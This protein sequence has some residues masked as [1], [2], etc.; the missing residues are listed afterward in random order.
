MRGE[1]EG[2][3][4]KGS[5]SRQQEARWAIKTLR[6]KEARRRSQTMA[7]TQLLHRREERALRGSGRRGE[8]EPAIRSQGL[9]SLHF[10]QFIF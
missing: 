2:G 5:L 6:W 10:F 8:G 7:A 9:L 4:G 3:G 1:G